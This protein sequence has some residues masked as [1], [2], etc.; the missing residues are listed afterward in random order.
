[1][2]SRAACVLLSCLVAAVHAT[3]NVLLIRAVYQSPQLSIAS[4]FLRG[5]GL[6]AWHCIW[7]GR[8]ATMCF[9]S[10]E[11]MILC[12]FLCL[13]VCVCVCVCV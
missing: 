11:A 2:A 5:N 1:M 8:D 3:G 9:C 6:G 7:I 13:C 4:L 10:N 12:L